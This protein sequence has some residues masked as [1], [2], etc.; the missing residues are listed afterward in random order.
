MEGLN[1]QINKKS[2]CL[3][4]IDAKLS[5]DRVKT[6]LEKIIIDIGRNVRIPGFRKGKVPAALIK[7]RFM[8]EAKQELLNRISPDILHEIITKE[9][10]NPATKPRIK[11]YSINTGEP[12]ELNIELEVYPEVQL[13]KYR[14]IKLEK[15]NYTVSDGDVQKTIAEVCQRNAVLKV[16]AGISADGDFVVVRAS[17]LLDDKEIDVGLPNE[18]ML[19]IGSEGI[20]PGFDANVK[21]LKKGDKKEFD[22]RFPENYK[23]ED[24]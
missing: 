21:G 8:E 20:L 13:K 3:I 7:D 16:K 11:E 17:A 9:K 22:Y 24:I 23:K 15:K 2:N 5:E 4:Y 6:E 10:I 1:Y 12:L 18:L 19:L 14:K